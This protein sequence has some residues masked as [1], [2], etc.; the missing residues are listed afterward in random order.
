MK[1]KSLHWDQ[2]VVLEELAPA[3]GF[4]VV[5]VEVEKSGE[6]TPLLVA[7]SSHPVASVAVRRRGGS[8]ITPPPKER[9]EDTL[10]GIAG[11]SLRSPEA[12]PA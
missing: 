1:A 6:G 5:A 11:S 3:V 12:A 2:E 9:G 8:A 10:G 4:A 7:P